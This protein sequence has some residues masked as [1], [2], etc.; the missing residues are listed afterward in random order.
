MGFSISCNFFVVEFC[1]G[2]GFVCGAVAA[3]GDDNEWGDGGG[4]SWNHLGKHR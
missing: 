4:R 1:G 3:E 2:T